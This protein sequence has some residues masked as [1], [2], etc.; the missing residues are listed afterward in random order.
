[1]KNK[2]D[3]KNLKIIQ[4]LSPVVGSFLENELKR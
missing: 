3:K 2:Y 4:K 1:M